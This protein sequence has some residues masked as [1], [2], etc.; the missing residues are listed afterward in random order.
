MLK[1]SKSVICS[2]NDFVFE[3]TVDVHKIMVISVYIE[4]NGLCF[5]FFGLFVSELPT[6]SNCSR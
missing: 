4:I 2:T 5:S 3:S 1:F 6:T